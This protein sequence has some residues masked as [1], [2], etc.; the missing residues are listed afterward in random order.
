[1]TQLQQNIE[2]PQ[3]IAVLIPT[4]NNLEMLKKVLAALFDQ[5]LLP[6][7]I[8]IS[9]SS[10]N[11]EIQEFVKT[12][13]TEIQIS[14]VRAGRAYK[15]DKL[16]LKIK[17]LFSWRSSS[18]SRYFGRAYPYEATNLAI[19]HTSCSWVAFLDAGTIP[20][21]SWLEDYWSF[22]NTEKVDV[23]FGNT[24]YL[25]S[26]KFQKTLRA[27]TYGAIGH[28]TAPGTLMSSEN[29]RKDKIIEG[30]RSGGDVEWKQRLK[31]KYKCLTP[32]KNYLV[33]DYLPTNIFSCT[34]KFF[35]Y[36]LHSARLDIQ[37][38]VKDIYLS[39]VLIFSVIL[40][41]KWNA[42]VGWENSPLFIPHITKI[43]LISL[44]LVFLAS[45]IFYKGILKKLIH[46]P[47][48]FKSSQ[49]IFFIAL[50]YIFFRWNAVMAGWVE[51][52]VWYV[53]NI[54]KIF[55]LSIL[56]LSFCYRGL[57]FPLKN[58]IPHTYLFPVNWL[59][60]AFVGLYLDLVKSP[61]YIL[62][63]IFKALNFK[64]LIKR[65]YPS[66]QSEDY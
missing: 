18:D 41:P 19:N 23:V 38:Q 47:F 57:Y 65:K 35:F 50:F 53:P 55:L 40:V 33:Y 49:Y 44:S 12:M 2:L 34:L 3:D 37:N 28:E 10:S 31:T 56:A 9:D 32:E 26:T 51:E 63:S 13:S 48:A 52:S 46:K 54:T 1:M 45:F 16:L 25:A 15:F 6:K 5:R 39:L 22:I 4:L 36:Q 64:N 14:Y 20:I 27:C 21:Q 58:K 11:N 42:F 7:E 66:K 17:D 8:V 60:V 59:Y 62:G 61:G 43:Y 29:F 30:V 24:M